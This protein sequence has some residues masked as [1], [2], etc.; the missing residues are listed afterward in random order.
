MAYTFTINS[1]DK[2]TGS[3]NSGTYAVN[4]RILPDDVQFY[5]MSF[6]FF[7][8]AGFY[9]DAINATPVL[10]TTYALGSINTNFL[11]SRSMS[12]NGSPSQLLGNIVRQID[13][14]K[15]TTAGTLSTD[16]VSFYTAFPEYTNQYK[17]ILKPQIE[18]LTIQILNN[19]TNALLVDT[20]Q[21]GT[22]SA[23]MT[24]WTLTI[25]LEPI[26][27]QLPST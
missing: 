14:M 4:F 16:F 1:K 20:V 6:S 21:D 18:N 12:S 25:T 24:A 19:S 23:D 15:L 17:V 13:Q 10:T 11:L 3:N 2:L 22:A 8:T 27:E 9:R 26:K 5:K 7:S